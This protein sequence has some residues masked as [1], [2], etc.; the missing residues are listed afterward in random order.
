MDDIVTQAIEIELNLRRCGEGQDDEIDLLKKQRR[1]LLT[2]ASQEERKDLLVYY[3][4]C[5][6]GIAEEL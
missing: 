5:M 4:D 6:A 3:M 2:L 1:D